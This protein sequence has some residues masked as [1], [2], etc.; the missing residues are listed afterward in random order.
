MSDKHKK[1]IACVLLALEVIG[2]FLAN[3]LYVRYFLDYYISA[4]T[5]ENDIELTVSKDVSVFDMNGNVELS[6]GTVIHPVYV[7]REGK[8]Y[9]VYFNYEDTVIHTYIST[10]G[11]NFVERDRIEKLMQMIEQRSLDEKAA[12]LRRGIIA[13]ITQAA[14]WLVIGGILTVIMT[15]KEKYLILYLIPVG[16]ALFLVLEAFAGKLGGY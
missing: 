14:V 16:V 12:E 2:I 7:A 6:K 8:E 1:V 10:D 11:S 9:K 15:K 5:I 3:F 13:G 4:H